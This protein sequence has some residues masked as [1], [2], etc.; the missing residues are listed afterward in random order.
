MSS[1]MTTTTIS[2]TKMATAPVLLPP[3]PPQTPP[4]EARKPSSPT[5]VTISPSLPPSAT[6]ASYFDISTPQPSPPKLA[7]P[8]SLPTPKP[9]PSTLLSPALPIPPSPSTTFAFEKAPP[10]PP[11]PPSPSSPGQPS[12]S[13][14]AASSR[15]LALGWKSRPRQGPQGDCRQ[16]QKFNRS[17]A[18]PTLLPGGVPSVVVHGPKCECREREQTTERAADEE[19]VAR[20]LALAERKEVRERVEMQRR[21]KEKRQR[22]LAKRERSAERKKTRMFGWKVPFFGSSSTSLSDS[23]SGSDSEST[24]TTGSSQH[25]VTDLCLACSNLDVDKIFTHLFVNNVPINGRCNITSSESESASPVETTPV[26]SVLRSPL[27]ATRPRAQIA[28][29]RLLLDLGADANA[30]VSLNPLSFESSLLSTQAQTGRITA[31]STT[32]VLGMVE[33]VS[34]LLSHGARLDARETN[35]PLGVDGRNGKALSALD[36][37]IM[38]GQERVVEMLLRSGASVT[39][40]C[41]LFLPSQPPTKSAVAI[42]GRPRLRSASTANLLSTRQQQYGQTLQVPS[43]E[44]IRPQEPQWPTP[45]P[46]SQKPTR[47][48]G[49]TPLHLAA[50]AGNL[51]MA[52][53]ITSSPYSKADTNARTS[54]SGSYTGGRTPLHYSVEA[55][56]LEVSSLL[57]SDPRTEV[58]VTDDE[59]AT[60]LALLVSK[61]ERSGGSKRVSEETVELVRRLLRAGAN[62][63]VRLGTDLSLKARL[64]ALD[65]ATVVDEDRRWER[66]FDEDARGVLRGSVKRRTF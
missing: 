17:L 54:S 33:A 45:L 13:L 44:D 34:L 43:M 57:L 22:K 63:G 39:A 32:C 46:I 60:P 37:A 12:Q 21:I 24:T 53:M 62:A 64:L 41:E 42:G 11:S 26:F 58:E 31:L 52:A 36:V 40:T 55:L 56:N 1:K 3:T 23:S 28:I 5:T 10:L 14:Q 20:V 38:A 18:I 59:G 15:L 47:L 29:L 35:L 27:F 51:G 49:V 48:S 61:V 30:S 19:L 6:S 25:H 50:M 66:L 9:S 16:L 65:T 7:K 8:T 2:M 4:L